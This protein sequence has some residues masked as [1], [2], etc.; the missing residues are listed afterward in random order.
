MISSNPMNDITR[1]RSR[2]AEL[3]P[4][5]DTQHWAK[6][7]P[8]RVNTHVFTEGRLPVVDLHDLNAKLA[9]RAVR[10]LIDDAETFENG[11]LRFVVGR[12]RHS[13]GPGGTLGKV[14]RKELK[15]AVANRDWKFRASGATLTLITD[16]SRAPAS[17]TGDLGLGFWI[18]MLGF[19]G[20]AIFVAG[21]KIGIW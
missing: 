12:G 7:R 6:T 8:W 17:A 3:E 20:A 15:R 14:V 11:A 16:P 10:A 13:M 19:A 9:R 4:E 21:T 2:L 5:A 18:L 1:I